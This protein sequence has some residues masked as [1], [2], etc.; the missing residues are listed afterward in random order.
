M[1]KFYFG[2]LE[3]NA[4]NGLSSALTCRSG[5]QDSFICFG[6]FGAWPTAAAEKFTE[7]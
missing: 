1:R 6:A 3:S 7:K 5:L 2:Y 4:V